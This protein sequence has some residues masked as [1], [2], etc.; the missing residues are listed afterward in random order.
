MTTCEQCHWEYKGKCRV[1][2]QVDG[3]YPKID[4]TLPS[5][6]KFRYKSQVPNY[7]RSEHIPEKETVVDI[8]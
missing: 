5:C 3:R 4:T 1:N 2:P 8:T 6:G 7:K